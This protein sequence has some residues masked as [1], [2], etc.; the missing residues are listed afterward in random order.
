[1]HC[2]MRSSRSK[3][4]F[5]R[6]IVDEFSRRWEQNPPKHF[7]RWGIEATPEKIRAELQRL[8]QELFK[9]A[10]TFEEPTVKILYKNVA[11]EN[12]R[13]KKFL[14]A[15]KTIMLERR[16]PR[17]IIDSLFESGEAAPESGAFL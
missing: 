12:I 17:A 5:E 4:E 8:A 16:V 1:L 10:I 6:R 9:R 15:L 14:E 11:L 7:A 2:T 13:D 3:S